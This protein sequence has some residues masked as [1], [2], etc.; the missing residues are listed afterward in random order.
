[1][2]RDV[3]SPAQPG[4]GPPSKIP[5]R[6]P[7][8][9]GPGPMPKQSEAA[10]HAGRA[11]PRPPG[12]SVLVLLPDLP[13]RE[14]GV[15]VLPGHAFHRTGRRI[16]PLVLQHVEPR[17][18]QLQQ[19]LL[20]LQRPVLS[21]FT[22]A[23]HVAMKTRPAAL[24]RGSYR[25]PSYTFGTIRIQFILILRHCLSFGI[26]YPHWLGLKRRLRTRG[27][28]PLRAALVA[29]SGASSVDA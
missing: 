10:T 22:L 2:A 20:L 11:E 24:T 6:A 4:P 27:G 23:V 28:R 15:D 25:S 9:R 13:R 19:I 1:M 7:P 14:T 18:D 17:P 21:A 8:E 26:I 29:A 12:A 3:R 5:S 16:D